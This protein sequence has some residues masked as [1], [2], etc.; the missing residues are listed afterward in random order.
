VVGS[1]IEHGIESSS[2]GG[3][4]A[5]CPQVAATADG[6]YWGTT[7]SEDGIGH[8]AVWPGGGR[9]ELGCHEDGGVAGLDRKGGSPEVG[10]GGR[11]GQDAAVEQRFRGEHI[12]CS[13][14]YRPAN[15]CN[16][17]DYFDVERD[18]DGACC[19]R[20]DENGVQ[21]EI[22]GVR[23]REANLSS[24]VFVNPQPT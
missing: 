13:G 21:I 5:E 17:V 11:Y 20:D 3:V 16:R 6:E 19:G 12:A 24:G 23:G 1:G 2:G 8:G 22:L 15:E 9:R 18:A 14:K 7:R 4:G 10:L